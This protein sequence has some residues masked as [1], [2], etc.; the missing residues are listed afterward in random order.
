[1]NGVPTCIC[2]ADYAMQ[3]CSANITKPLPTLPQL[4]P[5][6]QYSSEDKYGEDH[7]IF[8]TSTIAQIRIT[9]N[10]TN[11]QWLLNPQNRFEKIYQNATF[12]FYNGIDDQTF[13][14]VGIRVKGSGS[15]NFIKKSW[16]ISFNAF[17]NGQKWKQVN[18]LLM[19]DM[20]S[21]IACIRELLC[22]QMLYSLNCPAQRMSF[23][24]L[25]INDQ[26]FGLFW[27]QE[28]IDNDFLQSR[29]NNDKG[30]LYKCTGTFAYLGPY[31]SL[32]STEYVAETDAANNYTSLIHFLKILSKA[33]KTEAWAQ[34]LESIF[35]VDLF[36]R[37][38]I[39]EVLTGQYDGINLAKNYWLY[40]NETKF[41]FIRSDLDLAFG[42]KPAV[43]EVVYQNVY[44]WGSNSLGQILINAVFGIPRF[45]NGY[46]DYLNMTLDNYFN[47]KTNYVPYANALQSQITQGVLRDSWHV[48]DHAF[49]YQNF[50]DS[51]TK[52]WIRGDAD[53]YTMSILDF[54]DARISSALFQL[55]RDNKTMEGDLLN[56][57]Q[58]D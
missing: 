16:K 38:M 49:T 54:M 5:S 7:P 10:T 26:N 3:D 24:Q 2:P 31:P 36:L 25:F 1:V 52:G 55:G 23:A 14:S 50:L 40:M 32:Y 30:S 9:I 21:D 19:K 28:D 34:E 13:S 41:D 29:Y 48:M 35:N 33:N 44:T 42:Y 45:L 46:I 58:K 20:S 4:I 15:R 18:K 39:H 47:Y 56:N 8:N 51:M 6:T 27:L 11:L 37:T 22:R 12:W 57:L 43:Q 17:V 53:S